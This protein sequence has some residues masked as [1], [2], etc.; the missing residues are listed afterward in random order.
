MIKSVILMELQA[1]ERPRATREKR[2]NLKFSLGNAAHRN[3]HGVVDRWIS[4]RVSRS[5]FASI[6][7]AARS[8]LTS[9]RMTHFFPRESNAAAQKRF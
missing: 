5:I 4:S 2:I 1:T 6:H 3:W 7:C 9:F 8:S